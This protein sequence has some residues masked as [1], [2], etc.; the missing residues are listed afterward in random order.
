MKKVRSLQRPLII[1]LFM[2]AF[3][4][5]S[6]NAALA[7]NSAHR[8]VGGG[9]V[10]AGHWP[11]VAAIVDPGQSPYFGQF[12]GGVLIHPLWVATAAQNVVIADGS[13]MD[14][15]DIEVVLGLT[16]LLTDGG[17]RIAVTSIIVHPDY[18]TRGK[19]SDIALLELALPSSQPVAPIYFGEDDL[20]DEIAAAQGWGL[21]EFDN[22]PSVLQ[23]VEI[24]EISNEMG[25]DAYLD[26]IIP[27]T[28]MFAGAAD[29]SKGACDFDAGGP[30]MVMDNGVYRVAGL[31]SWVEECGV[32]GKYGAFTRISAVRD[33]IEA[34]VPDIQA[35][36]WFPLAF[37][38]G[39]WDTEFVIANT[40]AD[41]LTGLLR[42][43]N[44]FGKAVSADI[45]ISLAEGEEASYL[46]SADFP[47]TG[48]IRYMVLYSNGISMDASAVFTL[49][50]T[51][52]A[53]IPAAAELNNGDL[54]LP[55]IRSDYAGWTAVMLVNAS[56]LAK[57]LDMEFNTGEVKT[58]EIEA[59]AQQAFLVRHLFD[60]TPQPDITSAL[61]Q[62]TEG[63]VGIQLIAGIDPGTGPVL[64]GDVLTSQA[65]APGK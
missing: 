39:G 62:N 50:G 54:H 33:F 9:P 23:S 64:V 35:A 1:G 22:F 57:T 45:N 38:G 7:G 65:G 4:G 5:A 59:G 18:D 36:S 8:I 44:A 61:I 21:A 30:L 41:T 63:V 13:V 52:N 56:P 58:L 46:L 47:D 27:D 34:N 25:A 3:L 40:G 26:R 49:A 53:E 42:P 20:V 29:G 51:Y 32:P 37:T 48:A 31:F 11:A 43:C 2:L 6:M 14:P 12:G 19:G 60:G 15:A 16:D 10:Q 55:L 24:P 17:E 28:V